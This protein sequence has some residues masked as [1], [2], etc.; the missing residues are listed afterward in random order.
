MNAWDIKLEESHVYLLRPQR[1]TYDVLRT[2]G[3]L[4][5]NITEDSTRYPRRGVVLFGRLSPP[6]P[7][8]HH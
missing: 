6:L 5:G 8:L 7:G 2:Q 3:T 1:L 4:L